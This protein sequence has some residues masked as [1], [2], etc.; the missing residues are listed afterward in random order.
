MTRA[1]QTDIMANEL[2]KA[3]ATAANPLA[4]AA[5]LQ[6]AGKLQMDL[7]PQMQ[8]FAMRRAM[9]SLAG[10]G[11]QSEGTYNQLLGYMRTVNPEYAK[12]LEGRMVPGVGVSQSQQVPQDVRQQL[13]AK[14]DLDMLAKD[15]LQYSSTHTNIIPGT[16]EYNTGAAKAFNLKQKYR[17]AQLGGI[18]RQGEM[19]LLD[20]VLAANPAGVFKELSS[21]PKLKEMI[22]LNDMSKNMIL[23]NYGI[24]PWGGPTSPETAP[25]GQIVKRK[26]G[27]SWRKVPG[28]YVPVK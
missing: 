20:K 24:V 4:K 10:G 2:Q 23:K 26:D 16:P 14:Q 6:A 21:I 15:L 27:T 8:V 7:A 3:A 22:N 13:I 11:P 1:M 12:E 9:Q 19:P 28:G 5:A 25:Q 17:E 18:L